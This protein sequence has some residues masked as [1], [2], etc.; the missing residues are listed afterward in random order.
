MAIDTSVD[1]GAIIRCKKDPTQ[2][3][4]EALKDIYKR[5]R[6]GEPPTTANAKALL[7]RLFKIQDA[8]T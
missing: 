4:E 1:D 7:K 2:N 5:L 8:M 3:E 6:P